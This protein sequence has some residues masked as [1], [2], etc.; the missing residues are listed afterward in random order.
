MSLIAIKSGGL[1]GKG[2]GHSTQKHVLPQAN[3]DFVYSIIIE[4]YGMIF[5]IFILTLYVTIFIRCV[6]I[7]RKCTRKFSAVTVIGLG[8]AI[9]LQASV[10]MLV[11]VG[12]MPVTGQ[13]LPLLS[14]GGT[15]LI[16][17]C[18]A[19]GII[20]SVS[21]AADQQN[22]SRKKKQEELPIEIEEAPASEETEEIRENKEIKEEK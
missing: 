9:T 5:G 7:S 15:S 21:K 12:L 10:H 17:M 8:T 22:L 6:R 13:T 4:E 19:F 18:A 20:L 2:P 11:N 3:S 16:V 1:F 14:S